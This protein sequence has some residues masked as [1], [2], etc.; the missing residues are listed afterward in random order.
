VL[1]LLQKMVRKTFAAALEQS[2]LLFLK[3]HCT[4][5]L[6]LQLLTVSLNCLCRLGVLLLLMIQPM[7]AC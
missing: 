5:A 4:T 2:L 3:G 6:P 7:H 1:Y